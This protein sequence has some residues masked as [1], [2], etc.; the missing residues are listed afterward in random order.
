[1]NLN[2][3]SNINYRDFIN[4]RKNIFELYFMLGVY[5]RSQERKYYFVTSQN[6]SSLNL[7]I[8][9]RTYLTHYRGTITLLQGPNE[10]QESLEN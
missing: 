2:K 8:V 7:N 9:R 5:F 10:T 3:D 1:M 6:V 4:F